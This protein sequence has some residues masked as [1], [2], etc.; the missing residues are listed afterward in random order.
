MASADLEFF[1]K[2]FQMELKFQKLEFTVNKTQALE[3]QFM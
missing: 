2:K 3:A 1:N